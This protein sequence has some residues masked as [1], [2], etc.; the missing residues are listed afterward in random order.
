[1]QEKVRLTTVEEFCHHCNEIVSITIDPPVRD[2]HVEGEC[3]FCGN[4]MQFFCSTNK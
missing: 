3:P 1:M 2:V 4:R